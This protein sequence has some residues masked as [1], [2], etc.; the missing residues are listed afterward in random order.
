MSHPLDPQSLGFL[1]TDLARMLRAEM[2]RH[3]ASSGI[4]L[5]PGEVRL[6]AQAARS[7]LVRQS[8]LAELIGVEAMTVSSYVDRLEAHGLIERMPDPTDRRAKLIALTDKAG[9]VLDHVKTLAEETRRQIARSVDPEDWAAMM[10]ALKTIRCNLS[11]ARNDAR[12]SAA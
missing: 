11:D 3:I 9:A 1:I 4:G 8:V 6:L 12:S 10:R 7:G 5:T 2:D